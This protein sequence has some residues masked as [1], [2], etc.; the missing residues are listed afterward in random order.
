MTICNLKESEL[1]SGSDNGGDDDTNL[2]MP[3][4]SEML[5][6]INVYKHYTTVKSCRK[7]T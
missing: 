6:A 1:P 4:L 5:K 2:E 7:K 3:K